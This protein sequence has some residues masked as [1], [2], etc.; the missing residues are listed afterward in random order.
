MPI[1]V[2]SGRIG[3][4][5]T[6]LRSVDDPQPAAGAKRYSSLR[7]PFADHRLVSEAADLRNR[8]EPIPTGL[9]AKALLT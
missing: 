8:S 3:L 4:H 6:V 2:T 1:R 9:P 7:D 5:T